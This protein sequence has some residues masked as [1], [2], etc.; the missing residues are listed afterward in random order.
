[1]ASESAD[2][3]VEVASKT[4]NNNSLGNKIIEGLK[5]AKIQYKK[6]PVTGK[7]EPYMKQYVI[8]DTYKV[9]FRRDIGDFSH[10][11]LNHWNLELQTIKG[12]MKYDLHLYV[13]EFGNITDLIEYIPKK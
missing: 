9:V 3:V 1:M 4:A 11:D 2:D 10:G 13:D 12:N 5:N 6:N 7:M 8:D